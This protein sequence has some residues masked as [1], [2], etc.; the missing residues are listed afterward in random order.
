MCC[1][2][3]G[4]ER[5]E[6]RSACE[7]GMVPEGK[8]VLFFEGVNCRLHVGLWVLASVFVS[9]EQKAFVAC[10]FVIQR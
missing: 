8:H 2:G 3:E 5:E 4:E 9:F 10:L 6:W 1:V 7:E